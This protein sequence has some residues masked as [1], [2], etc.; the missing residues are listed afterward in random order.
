MELN[1]GGLQ[2]VMEN[3]RS[4]ENVRRSRYKWETRMNKY[5]HRLQNEFTGL[6]THSCRPTHMHVLRSTPYLSLLDM[7]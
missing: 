2:C 6:I 3:R 1:S 7:G 5:A 4:F